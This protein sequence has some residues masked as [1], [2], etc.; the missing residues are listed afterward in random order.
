MWSTNCNIIFQNLKT[1]SFMKAQCLKRKIIQLF[2]KIY[3]LSLDYDI[4][5]YCKNAKLK[6]LKSPDE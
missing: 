6:W 4:F 5:K 2:L 1:V 3:F